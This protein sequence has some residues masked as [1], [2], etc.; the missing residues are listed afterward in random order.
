MAITLPVYTRCARQDVGD[1]GGTAEFP[2]GGS[3]AIKIRVH[4]DT[5]AEADSPGIT[6]GLLV[7]V[8]AT[9]GASAGNMTVRVY[10]DDSKTDELLNTVLVMT[11]PFKASDTL[12]QPVPFF[13]A[14]H[15]T[16]QCSVD[17]GQTVFCTF[18]VKSMA[19]G[20]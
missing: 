2:A 10:S 6:R 4:G 20:L 19:G 15:F 17:P 14:P 11:S 9:T 7:G 16:I 1:P 5:A 8:T 13:E 18:Y 3:G 12:A